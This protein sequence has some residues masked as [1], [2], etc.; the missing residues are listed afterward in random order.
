[1]QSISYAIQGGVPIHGK[2]VC[3]GAKNLATKAMIASLLCSD[4]TIL[5]GV[6][7]IGDVEI[8]RDLLLS[9]GI[10]I[11]WDRSLNIM[12]LD[13]SKINGHE[14][15][16]PDTKSN[17][18][19]IL[20]LSILL[21][22][23]GKAK[24]PIV[25]GDDIGKR[26]VDYHIEAIKKFG[27]DVYQKENS[28]IAESTRRMK[29]V[30]IELPYPSVGATETCLFLGV[31]AEGTSVVNNVALEPEIIELIIMLRSMGAIISFSGNRRLVIQGVQELY[32]TNFSLM[33]D[34]IEAASWASLACASNG[35]IEISGI[36]PDLLEN[37]L[38][39]FYKIG[40]GFK[41]LKNNSI[42]FFR[43]KDLVSTEVETDVYPGFSTDL[44]QPFA[45]IL[46]QAKGISVIHETLYEKRFD[47]LN[48]L[49]KLGAKT[50]TVTSCLGSVKCRYR[51]QN[52]FHSAL[53]YGPTKLS[54]ISS[55][56]SIPDLRAGLSYFI[57]A[58]L[59]KGETMLD[60]AEQ[61]ERGYGN[62]MDKL[63]DTNIKFKRIVN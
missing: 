36:R 28:Y 52:H 60:V 62:L 47:Y 38:P 24:V 31:L 45:T 20:L 53:I 26:K 14:V 55:P 22:R 59:S 8:T 35:E 19:P 32:G 7:N 4:Q 48:A 44:Q 16:L 29:A 3:R 56:L 41:F 11:K 15:L 57:A 12:Y 61:I 33:G 25:G 39:Y 37:F 21:H 13:T 18:L 9:I 46:T 34:R 6:P 51:D 23:L 27:A 49:N 2:I 1:M 10:K 43:K 30:H 54:A 42:L 50:K 40:G 17:R 58:V 63:K 5:R